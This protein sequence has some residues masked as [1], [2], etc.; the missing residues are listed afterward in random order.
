MRGGVSVAA[1]VVEDEVFEEHEVTL[2]GEAGAAV[3]EVCAGAPAVADGAGG[4]ELVE[5]GEGILGS[6]ERRGE[7]VPGERLGQ[8]VNHCRRCID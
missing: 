7:G 1:G 6:G 8:A 2:E 4:E 5:A 3:G